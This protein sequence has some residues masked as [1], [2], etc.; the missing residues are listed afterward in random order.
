M[1]K[2]WVKTWVAII[3]PHAD[4]SR[5]RAL[6]VFHIVATFG[7]RCCVSMLFIDAS[8]LFENPKMSIQAAGVH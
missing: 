5:V 3:A 2:A 7:R 1:R 8:V 6:A 4:V